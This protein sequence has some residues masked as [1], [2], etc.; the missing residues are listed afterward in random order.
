MRFASTVSALAFAAVALAQDQTVSIVI[1]VC[2]TSV[3]LN[4]F[5]YPTQIQVGEANGQMALA[6]SPAS[7]TAKNGSVITFVFDGV[8]GNHTVAQSTF[9]TPC[10]PMAGG[11]DSGFFLTNSSTFGVW[12]LTITDDTKRECFPSLHSPPPH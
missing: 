3:S 10:T 8:P 12:N 11:F 7:I 5:F 6:F 1:F 2:S 9:A 4:I